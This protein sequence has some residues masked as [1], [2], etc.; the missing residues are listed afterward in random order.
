MNS[1]SENLKSSIDQQVAPF[2]QKMQ[3]EG[4]PDLMIRSF[5]HYFEQLLAGE[6]GFIPNAE[7]GPVDTLPDASRLD[8]Y[9]ESG[10]KALDKTVILKLNG[11]LGTSMGMRG[12]KSLLT[13][14]DGLTFLEIIVNQAM[15]L[16]EKYNLRLP[17][18][19]MNSFN[20][21]D[22]TLAELKKNRALEQDIPFGFVQHKE[23]KI[24]VETMTPVKWQADPAKEWCPPGHGDLYPALVTSGLLDQMLNAGYDYLFVSNADNLGATLDLK[25]LGYFAKQ[26][27]PFLMEVAD[28]TPADSKGGHLARRADGQLIL[29]E[30]AQCPPE[31]L[32]RFQDIDYY[33]YFNTNSLWV[34]LPTLQKVLEERHGVLGLPLIRNEKPVDPTLPQSPRVYQME[35]AMGSAIAI[36][37]GAE[38]M[39]V[40]RSRFVPVKKNNDLLLLMSDVYRLTPEQTLEQVAKQTPIVDLD[41]EYYQLID[42]LKKRFPHGAPS[43]I[44]CTSMTVRG[45][46]HFGRDVL[47]EGDVEIVNRGTE[48][49]QIADGAKLSSEVRSA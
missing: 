11:G 19:L 44:N 46:V 23:P 21:H 18:L 15:Y 26:E 36:F 35:T 41:P 34:H 5:Q 39:R 38:A 40:P 45:D 37:D 1:S 4:L 7:A 2:R 3:S 13:V 33:K 29:R 31:D 10:I 42:D 17:L 14:K 6:T 49:L 32:E 30:V 20:T 12:P 8:N 28:R 9:E 16:R 27:L 48:A 47:L 24:H 25:I 22:A 43:L